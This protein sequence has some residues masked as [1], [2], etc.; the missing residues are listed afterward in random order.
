MTNW[1]N[2]PNSQNKT[3]YFIV[4]SQTKTYIV[5]RLFESMTIDNQGRVAL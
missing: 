3:K 5:N 4:K 2:T 1:Q